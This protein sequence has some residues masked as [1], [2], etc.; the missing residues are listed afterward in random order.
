MA[1]LTEETNDEEEDE[2]IL[3]NETEAKAGHYVITDTELLLPLLNDFVKCPRCGFSVE[4]N[5][6]LQE[7]QGL[8]QLIKI[9]CCSIPCRWEKSGS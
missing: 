9:S 4:S 5:N 7:K 8:A 3:Q 1:A 2:E 6:I